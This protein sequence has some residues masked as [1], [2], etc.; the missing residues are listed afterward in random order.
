MGFYDDIMKI[1]KQTTSK[2]R[3]PCF[4][5]PCR[6]RLGAGIQTPPQSQRGTSP[7]RDPLKRY[8]RLP[9][10]CMKSRTA[11]PGGKFPRTG[12]R[13]IPVFVQPR[14]N[15]RTYPGT[16]AAKISVEEIQLT[17]TSKAGKSPGFYKQTDKR[18][19]HR[20]AVWG[21]DTYRGHRPDREF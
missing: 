4:P 19:C 9:M 21:I 8:L 7:S 14:T 6:R 17:L 3:K 16:P 12:A 5:L 15:Q 13:S 2:K 1:V 20:C 11:L 10:C 18:P